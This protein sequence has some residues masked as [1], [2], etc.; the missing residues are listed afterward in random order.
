MLKARSLLEGTLAGPLDYGAVSKRIAERNS[1]LDDA[2]ACFD[3]GE[4]DFACG[5]EVGI[6]AGYIGDESGFRLEVKGHESIVDCEGILQKLKRRG[7][8]VY[9]SV[10]HPP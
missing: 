1:K 4:N 3:G 6:A 7:D 8:R 5:G 9:Y 10:I 2:R